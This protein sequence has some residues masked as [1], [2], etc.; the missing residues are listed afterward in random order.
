MNSESELSFHGMDFSQAVCLLFLLAPGVTLS[1][2]AGSS[3]GPNSGTEN[4]FSQDS[5]LLF[6][7]L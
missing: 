7:N 4:Y 6:L 2:Q 3:E 5:F 1:A